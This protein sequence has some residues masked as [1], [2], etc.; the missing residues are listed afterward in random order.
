MKRIFLLIIVI[1]STNL[2]AQCEGD[3]NQDGIVNV[4]DVVILVSIILGNRV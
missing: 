2:Y 3:T 1:V 4:L